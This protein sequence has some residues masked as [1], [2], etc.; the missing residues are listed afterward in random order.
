VASLHVNYEKAADVYVQRRTPARSH[1]DILAD[2]VAPHIGGGRVVVDLAAGPGTFST[3]LLGWGAR[4]VLAVE[5]STAMQ[6]KAIPAP[7]VDRV[8]GRAEGIPLRDKVADAIWI[9]TAFHHFADPGRAVAECRRVLTRPGRVLMRGLVPGHTE[10][11]YFDVFPGIEKALVRFQSF[12]EL[13]NLFTDGG[14]HLVHEARVEE[15][16]WTMA[17]RADF[18]EQMRH[19]DSILTALTDDEIDA[20]IDALR[21]TPDEMEHFALSFLVFGI[22]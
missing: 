22:N 14:F 16:T 10:L 18:C 3:A 4:Y 12:D 2:H 11:D 5:P 13:E 1:L 19:A 21:S 9:S 17:D 6:S 7:G 8:R 15:F 20:G